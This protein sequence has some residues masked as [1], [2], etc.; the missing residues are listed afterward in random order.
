MIEKDL[1]RQVLP[2]DEPEILNYICQF[3][4]IRHYGKG[5][6]IYGIG[7]VQAKIYMLLE[8]IVQFYFLDETQERITDSFF[9]G[10]WITVNTCEI[11]LWEQAPSV[12]AT[13]AVTDCLIWEM[14]M[15]KVTQL[16][17]LYP[18]MVKF[19]IEGLEKALCLQ[20]EI[21]KKR[22]YLSGIKR[23]EW[24][25]EKWPEID[26][27]ASNH[28]IATFL[29]M[30]SE[31]LSRLRYQKRERDLRKLDEEIKLR[32]TWDSTMKLKIGIYDT[33]T[34]WLNQAKEMIENYV[35]AYQNQ[36]EVQ[37]FCKFAEIS[38]NLQGGERKAP[39]ILFVDIEKNSKKVIELVKE[40]NRCRPMCQVVYIS[41]S[42]THIM[43]IYETKHLYYVLKERFEE[44]LPSIMFKA[45]RALA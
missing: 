38:E 31:S 41:S 35:K 29:G 21:N 25:C 40:I 18:K 15:E 19:Y 5:E 37:I 39:H 45:M 32:S 33:E 4:E 30:R 11:Y 16:M 36:V 13:E 9:S 3:S 27:L 42:F 26:Q 44:K 2:F 8:G 28:Q 23:Y 20:N 7:E 22:L 6:G 17:Q 34:I 14:A 24:F 12:T 10:P 1:A 43:D